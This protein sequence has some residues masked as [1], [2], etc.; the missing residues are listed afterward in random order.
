MMTDA[1]PYDGL[2]NFK[3]PAS[4]GA[5]SGSLEGLGC[6]NVLKRFQAFC[7]VGHYH[8]LSAITISLYVCMC[9][10]CWGGG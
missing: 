2:M 6:C 8:T 7:P 9:E 1:I 5:T 3:P 4:A 10:F